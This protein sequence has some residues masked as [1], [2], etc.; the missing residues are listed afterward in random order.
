MLNTDL[1]SGAVLRIHSRASQLAAQYQRT[2][3]REIECFGGRVAKYL[4]DGVMAYFGWP[5]AHGDDPE[6]AVRA[7]LAIL[8]AISKLNQQLTNVKLSARVGIG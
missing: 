8:G 6:R 4:G 2:T 5:E 7:G 3:A 1:C